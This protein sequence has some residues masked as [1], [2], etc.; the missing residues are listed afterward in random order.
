MISPRRK[1]ARK[2]IALREQLAAALSMLLPQQQRDELRGLR[3]P[4]KSVIALFEFHHVIFHAIGGNDKWPNLTPMRVEAHRERSRQDTS[5]IAKGKR[6]ARKQRRH[7]AAMTAKLLPADAC[8][9]R[10]WNHKRRAWEDVEGRLEGRS[11]PK[12][13]IPSRPFQKGHRPLR[14]R[15]DLRRRE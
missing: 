1:R 12:R 7:E 13:R 5:T 8:P 15:N 14:S 9:F 6:I 11:W 3:V 4:A 2:H 10:R